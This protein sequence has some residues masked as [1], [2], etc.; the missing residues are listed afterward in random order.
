MP[1]RYQAGRS[2]AAAIYFLLP[3]DQVS[4]FHRLK[5]DE[6]WCYHLGESLTIYLIEP[7]GNVQRILLGPNV[8]EGERPQ[9]FLPHHAWFGAKV[10]KKSAYSLISCMTAPAFD[11]DDFELAERQSLLQEYP[12]HREII[13]MLT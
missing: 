5:C 9:I 7:S 10:N 4:K 2:C 11:Y 8:D 6:I 1:E 3:G 13:E 12:Q